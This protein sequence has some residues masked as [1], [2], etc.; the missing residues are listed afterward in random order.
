MKSVPKNVNPEKN[1]KKMWLTL[2]FPA[3]SSVL[4]NFLKK[5]HENVI[6]YVTTILNARLENKYT[7]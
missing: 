2:E 4:R 5:Y 3:Y 6:E 1:Y 7:I